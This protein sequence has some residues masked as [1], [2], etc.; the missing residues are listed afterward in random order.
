M[1]P[2]RFCLEVFVTTSSEKVKEGHGTLERVMP[3]LSFLPPKGTCVMP[4][5]GL[6]D[7]T[8]NFV[9]SGQI[10]LFSGG[11]GF[12]WDVTIVDKNVKKGNVPELTAEEV[13]K[14]LSAGWE[15]N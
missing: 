10:N 15:L 8:C 11:E 2:I 6:D 14:A 5:K 7:V 3:G 13:E 4:L 1:N 9:A 12:E